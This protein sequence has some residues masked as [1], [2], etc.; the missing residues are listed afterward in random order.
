MGFGGT[1]WIAANSTI[2]SSAPG[3]VIRPI[4][5]DIALK[6]WAKVRRDVRNTTSLFND[7]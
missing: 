4:L 6:S 1:V 5:L 7:C 3:A 2:V